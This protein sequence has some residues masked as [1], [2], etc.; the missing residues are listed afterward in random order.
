MDL[1]NQLTVHKKYK[2]FTLSPRA[3][4]I[5][6]VSVFVSHALISSL[7]LSLSLLGNDKALDANTCL[8][9]CLQAASEGE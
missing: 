6:E 2:G 9:A 4:A 5:V 3:L 7:S 1:Y 8:L